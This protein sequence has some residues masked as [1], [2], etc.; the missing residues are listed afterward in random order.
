MKFVVSTV[1]YVSVRYYRLI[2]TRQWKFFLQTS[3]VKYLS[4]NTFHSLSQKLIIT[5][6][7]YML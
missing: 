7:Y 2:V 5:C 3:F 1:N 6:Y 4:K